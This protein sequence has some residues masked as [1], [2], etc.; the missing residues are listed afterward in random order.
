MQT[1]HPLLIR[2]LLRDHGEAVQAAFFLGMVT[3]KTECSAWWGPTER[4]YA[5]NNRMFIGDQVGKIFIVY[6]DTTADV[7]PIIFGVNLWNY[8]LLNQVK[9]SES[10]LTFWGA[11]PE[12]FKSDP[13]ARALLDSSL[14]LMENDTVKGG[15]YILGIRTRQQTCDQNN[16]EQ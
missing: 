6:S 5:F 9:A 16:P 2:L 8:E 15:K 10:Y 1:S 3:E 13:H 12:P 4:W 7:I 14:V 11:Y